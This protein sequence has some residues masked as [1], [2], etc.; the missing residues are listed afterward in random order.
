MKSNDWK[1]VNVMIM[2]TSTNDSFDVETTPEGVTILRGNIPLHVWGRLFRFESKD[3]VLDVNA[4][5]LA[6]ATIVFGLPNALKTYKERVA[7]SNLAEIKSTYHGLPQGAEQWLAFGK[8]GI[9]CE[10]IFSH[11]TGIPILEKSE[12]CHPHDAEDF[13]RCRMLLNAV[14]SLFPLLPKMAEVSIVWERLVN[15]WVEICKTMN[16]EVYDFKKSGK[17]LTP[18]TYRMIREAIR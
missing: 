11:L 3:F 18:K 8:R 15:N 5:K 4:A 10:T 12:Y 16:K 6:K 9:S 17:S 1:H 2:N 14:P 13:L 7:K